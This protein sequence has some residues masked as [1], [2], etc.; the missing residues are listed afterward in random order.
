MAGIVIGAIVGSVVSDAVGAVG[1]V[2]ADAVLG[3]VIESGARRAYASATSP[4]TSAAK[5]IIE[6]LRKGE[7]PRTFA[8]RDI[9]RRGWAHLSER[10][11]VQ[12]ALRLLCDLDWLAGA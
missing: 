6:K 5:A 8:A 4:E 10:E 2:V 1:A 11:H 7:L 9:Y 3:T 12:D